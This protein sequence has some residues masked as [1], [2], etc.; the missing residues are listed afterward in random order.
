MRKIYTILSCA[1]LAAAATVPAAAELPNASFETWVDCIPWTSNDNTEPQDT[2]P[3]SWCISNVIG[4]NTLGATTVG[5]KVE[6]YNG[7]NGVKVYNNHN[8][9]MPAQIVPGYVTLGTTWSTSNGMKVLFGDSSTNDGGTF[10]GI[11]CN[12]RPDGVAFSYIRGLGAEDNSQFATVVAYMWTGTFTQKDVPGNIYLS[13]NPATVDMVDR[14]RNILGM[15]TALGGEVSKT[16]GAELIASVTRY[17]D[18]VNDE[19]AE[20]IVPFEYVSDATP[21]KINIIFAANDYFSADNI[22]EG[23]SLSVANPR[24]VYFS[25]LSS[26][27]V[28]G[29]A[30]ENFES[31]IYTY[32]VE[33][34]PAVED[35]KY[36]VLGQAA[37]AEI[38]EEDGKIIIT[39]TNAEGVD[40]DGESTHVYT[41]TDA[42][43]TP[44]GDAINYTGTLIVEMGGSDLTDGG[45]PATITITPNADGSCSF[46]LPNLTLG[47]LGTLGDIKLDRVTTETANGVST[48]SAD[49]KDFQLMD[50]MIT[51]DVKLNGTTTED[52]KADMTINVMWNNMPIVCTFKG[53]KVAG[54]FGIEADDENAPIE[55][56]NLNGVRVNGDNLPAGIYIRRQGKKVEKIMIR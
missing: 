3:E 39:V 47:D 23:N 24:L 54:I 43:G 9:M 50:G 18:Q 5:G 49:V 4:I 33:T 26:I 28:S 51:A 46:L 13:G 38:A 15:E 6:A 27:E 29:K 45:I 8:P 44:S 55:M 11:K 25:Q 34:L 35:V 31:G 56:Y 12:S 32:Y 21:E 36:E 20:L 10:G 52:G 42:K 30:I 40:A 22:E 7:L 2:T 53:D 48:Y 37:K 17:I 14:D 16:E 41:I 19:W 1:T